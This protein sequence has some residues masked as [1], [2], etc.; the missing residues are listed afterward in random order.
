MA[1]ARGQG[2]TGAASSGAPGV[3]GASPPGDAE[4]TVGATR[5]AF[6]SAEKSNDILQEAAA[7]DGSPG[8]GS[9]SE[10]ADQLKSSH[11]NG[12]REQINE[13]G[14]DENESTH[15]SSPAVLDDSEREHTMVPGGGR[16][17]H[18]SRER[19]A[20]GQHLQRACAEGRC[21]PAG[22]ACASWALNRREQARD[23]LLRAS[24]RR[25]LALYGG[26][27][28]PP[29]PRFYELF[30]ITTTS[31]RP[32]RCASNPA[33][34]PLGSRAQ[35]A[36]AGRPSS[37]LAT[38]TSTSLSLSPQAV[39]AAARPLQPPSHLPLCRRPRRRP[40]RHPRP[41]P[42]H[43]RLFRHLCRLRFRPSVTAPCRVCTA[44]VE[45]CV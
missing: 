16:Q 5:A 4:L 35:I 42:R 30:G 10:M 24:R 18:R 36:P 25:P 9:E 27:C 33:L 12:G 37:S 22:S 19:A 21:A 13:V 17:H 14:S 11:S 29:G 6:A 43:R 28:A 26:A 45:K 39:L 34:C 2:D 23:R 44:A 8:S 38:L 32:S 1:P 31:K 15:L 40:R 20:R 41:R 3:S 7:A